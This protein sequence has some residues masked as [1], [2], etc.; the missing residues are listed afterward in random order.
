MNGPISSS[1]GANRLGRILGYTTLRL[2]MGMSMFIHGAGRLPKISAFTESTLKMFSGSPLPPFAVVAF[3]RVTPA[4]EALI[5]V[6]VLL[7]LATRF[8]LT[9]G[10]LW[11]VALIFGS[12]LIEKYDAVG[13][14]LIYSLIFFHLLQ[15]LEQNTLSIDAVIA[16]R[17]AQPGL[18]PQPKGARESH[19]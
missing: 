3:A 13:I 6:L 14:Q 8:G 18:R 10:G 15:H 4:V 9:L 1:D 17:S 5:G 19:E 7:G 2:A 11:M 16:R 12:A